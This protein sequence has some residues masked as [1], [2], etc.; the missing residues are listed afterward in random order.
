M[1][2]KSNRTILESNNPLVVEQWRK[3]G[4]AEISGEDE[5]PTNGE[6]RD[7]NEPP[8]D[9]EPL[10]DGEPLSGDATQNSEPKKTRK[11]AQE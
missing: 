5:K 8:K 2:I 9:D 7:D 6:P 1:R 11:K 4:Y 3:A 10:T